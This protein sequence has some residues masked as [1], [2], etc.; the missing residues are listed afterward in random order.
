MIERVAQELSVVSSKKGSSEGM[1]KKVLEQIYNL[2]TSLNAEQQSANEKFGWC[3]EKR[4]E[5]ANAREKNHKNTQATDAKKSQLEADIGALKTTIEGLDDDIE[6][7]ERETQEDKDEWAAAKKTN[8]KTIVDAKEGQA[9]LKQAITVLVKHFVKSGMVSMNPSEA[10]DNASGVTYSVSGADGTATSGGASAVH[11]GSSGS[12][13]V[14]S[15]LEDTLA[16]YSTQEAEVTA[17]NEQQAKSFEDEMRFNKEQ[18]ADLTSKHKNKTLLK[19]ETEAKL[20]NTVKR[21]KELSDEKHGLDNFMKDLH[22]PC[23][24]DDEERDVADRGTLT[25]FEDDKKAQDDDRAEAK[26]KLQDAYDTL[27]TFNDRTY[28]DSAEIKLAQQSS[29]LKRA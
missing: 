26:T 11:T 7:N 23:G 19:E 21:L 16:A 22:I 2:I 1:F 4:T 20:K 8:E 24:K 10:T 27:K 28:D 9:A 5:N 25:E 6:E 15:L 18:H 17:S 13:A 12:T 3:V 14:L 29:F